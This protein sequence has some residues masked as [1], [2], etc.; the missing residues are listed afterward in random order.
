MQ[1]NKLVQEFFE[2]TGIK[3]GDDDPTIQMIELMQATLKNSMSEAENAFKAMVA[4]FLAQTKGELDWAN[5]YFVGNADVH[6]KS[7]DELFEKMLGDMDTKNKD[8]LLILSKIQADYDKI[9]DERFKNH[10]E[11]INKLYKDM[12]YQ[13]AEARQAATNQRMRDV[14]V[15]VM[16]FALGLAV[17]LLIFWIK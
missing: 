3:V 11:R 7:L 9:N 5:E 1:Q 4:D 6:K 15:G 8:L 12:A 10:F 16:G 14:V 13:G 2:K 17:C